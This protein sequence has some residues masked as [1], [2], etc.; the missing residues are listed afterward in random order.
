LKGEKMALIILTL[1]LIL[2]DIFNIPGH[3]PFFRHLDFESLPALITG[4]ITFSAIFF[5]TQENKKRWEKD[6]FQKFKNE[7]ILELLKM[8]NKFIQ[9]PQST[10]SYSIQTFITN[11]EM[12][13][14]E[15][16]NPKEISFLKNISTEI[17]LSDSEAGAPEKKS[18][19]L[20]KVVKIKEKLA[21]IITN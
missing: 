3:M 16:L 9:N 11:Q 2:L 12:F 18:D 13:L 8:L 5:V 1:I 20:K 19:N 15:Y 10:T 21:Q 7:Q 4:L 6:Y 17:N 14:N